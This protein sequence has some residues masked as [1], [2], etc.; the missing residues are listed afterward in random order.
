VKHKSRTEKDR[1]YAVSEKGVAR[2]RRYDRSPKGRARTR[3]W[4]KSLKG[5]RSTHRYNVSPKGQAKRERSLAKARAAPP[6]GRTTAVPEAQRLNPAAVPAKHDVRRLT[7]EDFS[8]VCLGE[9][10][11]AT[12]KPE[13]A[14]E[15][16]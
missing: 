11:H 15:L 10:S 14:D 8:G 7:A 4:R 13:R 12:S 16:L 6:S 3:R 5:R 2:R 1:R 9:S